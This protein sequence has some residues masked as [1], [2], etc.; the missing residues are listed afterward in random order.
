[1][2]LNYT[3]FG[4][5]LLAIPPLAVSQSPAQQ[6]S[7]LSA[8]AAAP[9][10]WS[11]AT[12]PRILHV[13]GLADDFTIIAGGSFIER[14]NGTARLSALVGRSSEVDRMFQLDLEFSGLM[15]SADPSFPPASTI[16]YGLD[17]NAYAPIGPVD[18]TTF[19]YYTIGSGYLHGVGSY[20]GARLDLTLSNP[21]QLGFGAN[22]FNASNG[23]LA[24]WN[25]HVASQPIFSV[26]APTGDAVLRADLNEGNQQ[27]AAH[28]DRDANQSH[29]AQRFALDL[30][31][32]N[33][34]Y[35]FVP[36][37]EWIE[38]SDGSC[39]MSGALCH[40]M[41]F[42]D[43]WQL[44]LTGTGRVDPGDSAFPPAAGAAQLLTAQTYV[45]GGGWVDPQRYHYYTNVTARL[46]GEASNS[47]AVIDL[48]GTRPLQI[49]LGANNA[50]LNYGAFGEFTATIS[51]QASG[52]PLAVTG[53]ATL[54]ANVTEMCVLPYPNQTPGL[55]MVLDNVR[56]DYAMMTGHN[57]AWIEQL[58]FDNHTITTGNP[59]NWSYGFLRVLDS[60]NIEVHPPQGYTPG[61]YTT[62]VFTRSQAGGFRQITL[63]RPAAPV[64]RAPADRVSGESIDWFISQGQIQG[65]AMAFLCLSYTDTP[66]SLPGT[67]DLGIGAQFTDTIILG[68]YLTDPIT[69]AARI[70]VP[71]IP[72]IATPFRWFFQGIVIDLNSMTL[73]LATTDV[74][75][76][77]FR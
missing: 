24:T 47:G 40:E 50:N 12:A 33:S 37:G 61:T 4:I 38:K 54:R 28:A 77:D 58:V 14:P 11:T 15:T 30:P 35:V 3:A 39:L 62:R 45:A 43:R 64:V 70:N 8:E 17:P 5:A 72:A 55:H 27:C 41:D 75:F 63:N 2:N 56:G 7:Y 10:S 49:G 21:L 44:T 60:S 23:L 53:P 34:E 74:W 52:R 71:R 57:L 65:T 20:Q 18:P 1:M 22:N 19:R 29:V 51:S 66:S 76:T 59:R 26:M 25:I 31:G 9:D 68:A 6:N 13:P 69:G 36:A 32:V 42:D 48:V 67:L 16:P 46:D 73:P